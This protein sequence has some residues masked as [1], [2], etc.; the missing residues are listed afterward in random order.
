MAVLP[1]P[2]G[3][4]RHR[5]IGF[6]LVLVTLGWVMLVADLLLA[7]AQL[8]GGSLVAVLALKAD[9]ATLAQTAIVSGMGLAI[10]GGLRDGF[11]ALERFFE[12]VLQRSD[13]SRS[14]VVQEAPEPAVDIDAV[15]VPQGAN[16]GH[17]ERGTPTTSHRNYSI[18]PDGSVEVE[19]LLGTRVFASLEE[20]RDFIR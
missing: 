9:I 20:A 13:V 1:I 2:G 5:L 14:A 6:G 15:P 18:L 19:T 16:R 3:R 4:A 10:F 17:A 12:A 11:G 7:D 8:Q